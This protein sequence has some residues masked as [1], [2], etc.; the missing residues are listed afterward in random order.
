[1]RLLFFAVILSI[2][3]FFSAFSQQII[4]TEEFTSKP[5]HNVLVFHEDQEHISY[6]DQ[7]GMAILS[8]F[9]EGAIYLQHPSYHRRACEYIKGD[10]LVTMREKIISYNEVVVSANKWEQS[11]ENISQ[12]ILSVDK[13]SIEFQNPQ[14]SADLLA[15]TGQVFVQKSQLGGGSPKIRGFAANAVL[16]VVDG[17]RMNNAIFRSGNLQNVI[18]IDP[19]ALESSEVI[20]GPGS[21]I[22]GS[23]ALGGV[24]DFHTISPKWS[25]DDIPD[26]TAT[27]L[28]RYS[29][30]AGERTGHLDFS[31]ARNKF[32][33][34]HSTSFTAF[35]DLRAGGNRS[36]GYVGEFKRNFYVQHIDGQDQLVRN[37][38]VNLQK[39]SGYD[40]FN[41]ISKIKF[42]L[43]QNADIGYGYYYS[44]TSDIPRYD[45]LTETLRTNTDSLAHAEWYYGPQKWQMHNLRLN[46]YQSSPIFDQARLIVAYQNFEE[47]RNDRPFADDR[48]RIRTE[49]VDMYVASLDFDKEFK[50]SNCYYGMDFYHNEV[51]SDA[52]RRNISS[53]EITEADSRYP[54]GG[55]EYTSFA[56]YG[57]YINALSKKV[58]L[59]G[60]LR[61]NNVKLSAKT[62]NVRAITNN[63]ADIELNNS[64]FNGSLGSVIKLNE[65]NKLSYNFSTGF[66]APNVDD[67][68]KVFEVGNR[69]TVPNPDLEPEYTVSNEIAYEYKNDQV[70]LKLVAFY[71][72][73][74]DAI[75]DDSFILNESNTQII[76]DDT[77]TI[78]AK[79]N[80]GEG[81]IYGGSMNIIAEFSNYWALTKTISYTGGKDITNNQPLRHTTP[82]FGKATLTYQR[83]KLR[84]E[85]YIEYNGN[86]NRDEIPSTEIDDKPHL[87]TT[88]GSPGWYTLNIKSSYRFN[89]KLNVNLGI[90]NI[91]D[92]HYRPTSS[93]ISAPGRNLIIAFRVNI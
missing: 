89:E 84:S 88:K 7:R 13:K 22:Y 24:M 21:V 58:I 87:Y 36:G 19:N 37:E 43:G 50:K 25:S 23:D 2:N 67:V 64:A 59:N 38:D 68:G 76:D 78:R 49:N 34:F 65:T 46:Y 14:T 73:L 79:V 82:V 93:G 91:F 51:S 63:L 11:E 9:P 12:Q 44:T 41:T 75:I 61:F 54:S 30:A 18:N 20:F 72:H 26:F 71:S 17:V 90:E 42:R 77:L 39:F 56:L 53:G 74:F 45:N 8:G 1:M 35:D 86:R 16:L 62:M 83:R 52:F 85:F 40:L 81:V 70:Y 32:T 27:S 29:S 31:Y 33:F 5:I 80:I 47:I 55:S 28:V 3:I 6:T 66:R 92:K 48:L 57:S 10:L 4:V 60:G 15:N 69:L